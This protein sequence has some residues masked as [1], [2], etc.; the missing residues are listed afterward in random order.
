LGKV[1]L[2]VLFMLVVGRRLFP[3]LLN[4]VAKTGSRELFTLFIVGVALGIA[5]GSAHLFGV[6]F[7]LGAFFAGV[8]IHES[9]LAH[10]AA[11]NALPM[12]DA[13]AVLFFV[14]VGMLF[15][16]QIIVE[17]PLQVLGI[18]LIIILGKTLAAF[19]LILALR[20][21]LSTAFMVSASLAQ[22]GEF[23]FI[24]ANLGTALGL[25]PVE[26]HSLVL[27]GAMISIT[28]NPFMFRLADFLENRL[29]NKPLLTQWQVDPMLC[30][31]PYVD[32]LEKLQNHVVIVGY[33]RVGRVV[34]DEL[35]RQGIPY[36]VIEQ[37]RNTVEE[38]HE[39]G[40][41][42]LYGDAESLEILKLV[43]LKDAQFFVATPL[44]SFQ[45][46]KLV[47]SAWQINPDIKIIVRTHSDEERQY[48]EAL[49]GDLVI[50]GDSELALALS[51]HI[52]Q[53]YEN[54]NGTA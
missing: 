48:L 36:I 25:L 23:A 32:T 45:A 42:A 31:I 38:L 8:V 2:F 4:L 3:W 34:G 13:F 11:E 35:T 46:R 20:Y 16:P 37:N 52:L 19:G 15:N 18:I 54:I 12:Q 21:P 7:A 33:G 29:K 49:G 1:A 53:R 10:R 39:K 9:H 28:L 27:A 51:K 30:K 22:I 44:D 17:Q 26:A 43:R 6:S 40:I 47:S 41:P 50:M 14:S 24:L 5:Y